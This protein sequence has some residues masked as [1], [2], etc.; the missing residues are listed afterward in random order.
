MCVNFL[1]L[2]P[3]DEEDAVVSQQAPGIIK[4]C[5]MSMAFWYQKSYLK[6][7]SYLIGQLV[8]VEVGISYM[9]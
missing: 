1:D 4:E 6:K 8:R 2:Q 9:M 3:H 5:S 7:K